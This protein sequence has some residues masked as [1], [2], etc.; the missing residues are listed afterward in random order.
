MDTTQTQANLKS[1]KRLGTKD[2]NSLANRFKSG[3]DDEEIKEATKLI[4]EKQP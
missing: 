1:F 4:K 3:D 2:G